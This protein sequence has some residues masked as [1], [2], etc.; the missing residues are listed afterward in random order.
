MA[1]LH[2]LLISI[3]SN[4]DNIP[5]AVLSKKINIKTSFILSIC[6][7]ITL[8]LVIIFQNLNLA[9]LPIK[10]LNN[11]SS[12]ILIIIGLNTF[13]KV[14]KE[15]KDNSSIIYIFLSLTLNNIIMYFSL[16]YSRFN[17]YYPIL[18]FI[19]SFIFFKFGIHIQKII[20][21]KIINLISAIL[22]IIVGLTNIFLE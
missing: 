5:I 14:N 22:L 10:L 8:S 16:D 18:N 6:S 3:I 9:N 2:L 21:Y 20:K 4:L 15:Y 19:F 11:I 13:S 17:V 12:F 7:S 1:I